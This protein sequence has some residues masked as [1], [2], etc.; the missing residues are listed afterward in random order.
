MDEKADA[1]SGRVR[2]A[3]AQIAAEE[4]VRRS[5][6]PQYPSKAS[7]PRSMTEPGGEFDNAVTAFLQERW[8]RERTNFSAAD[9]QQIQQFRAMAQMLKVGYL[10]LELEN[11]YIRLQGKLLANF[12]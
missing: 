2:A 1:V 6:Y 7:M 8:R 10:Q 3:L 5:R 9:K 11:N 12:R 4:Q